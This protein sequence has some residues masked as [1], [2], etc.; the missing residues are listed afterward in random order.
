MLGSPIPAMTKSQR[1]LP[2]VNFVASLLLQSEKN[3]LE[4][5]AFKNDKD[6][7]VEALVVS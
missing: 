6:G 7:R 5:F 3:T 2:S 1:F 4:A